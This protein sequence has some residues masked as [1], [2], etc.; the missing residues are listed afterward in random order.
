MVDWRRNRSSRRWLAAAA[1]LVAILFL[2]DIT[3]DLVHAD[4]PEV[5]GTKTDCRGSSDPHG[6]AP[7]PGHD[8]GQP[9]CAHHFHG[10]PDQTPLTMVIAALSFKPLFNDSALVGDRLRSLPLDTGRSPPL[11]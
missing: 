1:C 9:S 4:L 3:H 6:A 5:A 11:A 2:T 8:Y 10:Y 7:E